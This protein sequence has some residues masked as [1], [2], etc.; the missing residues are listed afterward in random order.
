MSKENKCVIAIIT[1]KEKLDGYDEKAFVQAL[2]IFGNK[3][4]IKLIVPENISTDYYD[5]YSDLIEICKIDN[6]HFKST[7]TY[8]SLCCNSMFYELFKDF[9]Y[10]LI[11]Q[12]D[13]WVFEDNLDYFMNLGYDW[14]GAPWPHIKNM[15]GNGGLSLR[16]VSKMLEITSNDNGNPNGEPEDT[17]FCIKHKNLVNPCDLKTACNFSLELVTPYYLTLCET[18]P[19]GFHNR[20]FLRPCF[21]EDGTKFLEYKN[22]ILNTY[23]K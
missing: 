6:Q 5:K 23:K 21:D 4:T 16:K 3:R 20:D 19:M 17:W 22:K 13:C 10:V 1:H 11:Y 14:Y 8:N 18:H 2:K 7:K 9:D 15:V 12:T